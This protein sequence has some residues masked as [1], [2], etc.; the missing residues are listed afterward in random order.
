MQKT[1]PMMAQHRHAYTHVKGAMQETIVSMF[2][3]T[4]AWSA[5]QILSGKPV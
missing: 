1:L 5:V 4:T 2:A 3:I